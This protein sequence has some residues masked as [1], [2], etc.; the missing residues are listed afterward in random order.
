MPSPPGMALAL[1]F[2]V[3]AAHALGELHVRRARSSP[4]TVSSVHSST[5]TLDSV[6]LYANDA[7]G[8]G[9]GDRVGEGDVP[10]VAVAV[11]DAATGWAVKDARA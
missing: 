4:A 8:E 3:T 11:G 5:S 6:A 9:D 1:G 7:P 2:R 10:K